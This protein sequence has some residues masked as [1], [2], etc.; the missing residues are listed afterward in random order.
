MQVQQATN[1]PNPQLMQYRN[2]W[3]ALV[4]IGRTEGVSGVYRGYA[5]T[6]ASFGPFSALYFC[7][8]ERFKHW[9]LQHIQTNYPTS[10]PPEIPFTYT[11]LSSCSAGALA[12]WLTSPLDMAK[13]RLQIQRGKVASHGQS[14][15]T[16]RGM[17]DCLRQA[18]LAGGIHGLFR[19]AGARVLHFAPATTVTMTCY[20]T[21][22]SYFARTLSSK[23]S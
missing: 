3:D 23:S 18:Y 22:R 9:S 13:L 8:Y 12:S 10:S 21:F 19:G 5:A 20:E 7:F 11:I 4:K 1:A 2:S 15:L 6:L 17:I 16:Y 14:Q